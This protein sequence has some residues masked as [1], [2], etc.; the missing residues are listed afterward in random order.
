MNIAKILHKFKLAPLDQKSER[1]ASFCKPLSEIKVPE[2]KSKCNREIKFDFDSQ[3]RSLLYFH[4]D[5]FKSGRDLLQKLSEDEFTKSV[6]TLKE[7]IKRSTFFEAINHRGLEQLQVIFSALSSK[8]IGDLPTEYSELGELV[9]VD[10]SFIDALY[11][12]RW[13]CYKT[14]SKKAK[15]HLGFD[16]NHKIPRQ[17]VLTDGKADEKNYVADLVD[18]NQTAILDRFYQ[19]HKHFDLWQEQ[20]I[21]FVCRI[22]ARTS[23]TVCQ[24]N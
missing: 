4:M 2:L 12:M 3:L 19:S 9:S 7:E 22:K 18:K 11:S 5:E 15:M 16:V 24:K 8:A 20:G 14:N 21:N 10:G 17:I 23:K 1:F 6:I 13:A